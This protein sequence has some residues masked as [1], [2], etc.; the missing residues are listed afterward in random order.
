MPSTPSTRL[1]LVILFASGVV[2]V[3]AFLGAL[4]AFNT[5]KVGFLNPDTSGETLAFTGLTVILFLLLI[6]LLMLL[7][8]NLL[9]LYAYQ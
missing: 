5:S 2:L 7:L 8:R 1:R 4:Q 3:L 9:K 6:A